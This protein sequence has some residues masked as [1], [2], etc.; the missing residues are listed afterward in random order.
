MRISGGATMLIRERRMP[1]R[2]I[3]PTDQTVP[4][5]TTPKD[6]NTARLERKPT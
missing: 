6:R 4:S 5:S 1:A 2:P 3:I